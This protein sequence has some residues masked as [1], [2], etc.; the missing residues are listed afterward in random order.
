VDGED[1]EKCVVKGGGVRYVR[2][3]VLERD[4]MPLT[5]CSWFSI[6]SRT[7]WRLKAEWLK[8]RDR[9][10]QSTFCPLTHLVLCS[11]VSQFTDP[12]ITLSFQGIQIS[13]LISA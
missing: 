10:L 11:Q 5:I 13:L 7:S 9:L 2:R 1:G 3:E 6:T 4:E 12:I 8:S